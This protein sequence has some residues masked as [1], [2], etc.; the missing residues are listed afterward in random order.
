MSDRNQ[1]I[2]DRLD[3]L[4]SAM[5]EREIDY[6]V[7]PT[8]DYHNSEYVG[9]YFKVREYFSGFTGSNGTLVVNGES[10]GLWT[11]GRYFIQAGKELTGT[12]IDLYRMGNEGV[13]TIAEYL[14]QHM[15]KGEKLGFDGRVCSSN[16]VENLTE[17]CQADI[18]ISAQEDVAG[19]VWNDRPERAAG[20]AFSLPLSVTGK[21][22]SE[23]LMAVR[24]KMKKEKADY[25]LLSKLDDIMW[26]Y[27]MRGGDVA[28]NPVVLS[29]AFLTRENQY[30]FI[31]K[32]AVTEEFRGYLSKNHIEVIAY[33]KLLSFLEEYAYQ[34]KV[35]IDE[36]DTGY[37]LTE[38]IKRHTEIVF[39]G[40]PTE[41]LKAVKN[42]TEL[43]VLQKYYE[44][45]S[46][47]VCRF[48]CWL[49]DGSCQNEMEAAAYLDNLRAQIDGFMGLS[50]PTISA[51]GAN[52]A[53]MHYEAD[54]KSNAGLES[55]GMLLVDSGGQYLGATT[56]VTR[57]ICMG[58]VSQEEKMYFTL[59]A[60]GML[61]LMNASFLEG[62]SGRNLDILAREPLWKKNVDYKCGTGHG[63]GAFLN[64]HEGPQGIRWKYIP[65]AAETVLQEGMLVT[66]EPGVYMEG[67]FGIR[68]E[69]VLLV[70][71]GIKNTDGQFLYFDTLTW[72]PIDLDG[73]DLQYM[74]DDDRTMLNAYHAL[75]YEKMAP[76]MNEKEEQW[77]KKATRIV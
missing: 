28:C 58:T 77:L 49:K 35:M 75:V 37:L 12:G 64:V 27:N 24:E 36:Y 40:N 74:N 57:T 19:K 34:G 45:D 71:K 46:A 23:K 44:Q 69:N 13:P 5:R 3:W 59:T 42:E 70:Q 17:H 60:C 7:I 33:D 18:V 4:R 68:T 31:Q 76:F 38:I 15:K 48:I 29:Y 10:A 65:G 2:I 51:Y 54:E 30:L 14:G 41:L 56:D 62:C 8:A 73:I 39:G 9:D 25:F 50:F 22:V 61:R 67:H 43:S 20:K 55:K 21:T 66:D 32:R 11:D 63:V 1:N 26:L 16:Y 47:A 52:A 72:V 53:M 6:Y